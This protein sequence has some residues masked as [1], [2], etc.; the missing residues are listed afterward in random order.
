MT[1]N[2]LHPS[3]IL[4]VNPFSEGP[5]MQQWMRRHDEYTEVEKFA[6]MCKIRPPG[7]MAKL[8]ITVDTWDIND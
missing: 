7:I 1:T 4:Y 2:P 6:I 3:D 5:G 8:E